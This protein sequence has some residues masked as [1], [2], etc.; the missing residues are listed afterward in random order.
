[1]FSANRAALGGGAVGTQYEIEDGSRRPAPGIKAALQ[2]TPVFFR[3]K[4]VADLGY[5]ISRS[6]R[7]ADPPACPACVL[8]RSTIRP[9]RCNRAPTRRPRA[10]PTGPRGVSRWPW[11]TRWPPP[12]S[13]AQISILPTPCNPGRG[14]A[15]A[16][17]DAS[18]CMAAMKASVQE[19]S[20]S[21]I[22]APPPR[23]R[24]DTLGQ[25]RPAIHR[26]SQWVSALRE[27]SGCRHQIS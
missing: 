27:S 18:L 4:H 22:W 3:R 5:E 9:S 7:R 1:M 26:C 16:R 12:G 2:Y 21:S 6:F 15:W 20:S 13:T 8:M 14:S 17:S 11:Q 25:R 19:S 24:A 10:G 23:T